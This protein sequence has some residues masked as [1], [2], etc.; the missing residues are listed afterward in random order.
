MQAER[1]NENFVSRNRKGAQETQ[2]KPEAAAAT[3]PKGGKALHEDFGKM[4]N[5]LLKRRQEWDEEEDVRQANMPDKDCPPGM[6][7]MPEGE[8]LE[9]LAVLTRSQET[10][11]DTLRRMPLVIETQGQVRRK[12]ELDAK[13]KEIEDAIV[14]FSREKV[15]RRREE[16]CGGGGVV[17]CGCVCVR[18]RRKASTEA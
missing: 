6:S 12:N 2:L 3:S 18:V 7:L 8:R 1:S 16:E 11:K 9:T 17:W 10:A 13:L 14:I 4:P 15:R 5:Y